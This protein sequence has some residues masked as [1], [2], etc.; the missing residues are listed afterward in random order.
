MSSDDAPLWL[1]MAGRWRTNSEMFNDPAAFPTFW[2][3]Q[4]SALVS[5]ATQPSP[6]DATAWSGLLVM[7]LSTENVLINDDQLVFVV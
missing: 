7:S 3:L 5:N 6:R 4:N 2:G 1:M